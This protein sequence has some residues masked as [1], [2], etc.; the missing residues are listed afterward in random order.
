MHLDL[1]LEV[2]LR[3]TLDLSVHLLEGGD[4]FLKLLN[5]LCGLGFRF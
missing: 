2:T 1:L 4:V 5:H 3:P